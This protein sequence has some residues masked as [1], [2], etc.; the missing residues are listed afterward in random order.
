MN[1]VIMAGGTGG[2]VFPGLAVAEALRERDHKVWWLGAEGGMEE[3]LVQRAEIEMKSLPITGLRGKG[4]VRRLMMPWRMLR[5]TWQA[6]RFMRKHNIDVAISMGGYVAAP[7][8]LACRT[9]KT[10][11]VVHEQNSLFGMTNRYLSK[12][13]DLV[14][15][16]FDLQQQYASRWVG[17]PVR[18]SIEAKSY[19]Y[20]TERPTRVLILGGSLGAHALN[21]RLPDKLRSALEAGAI[22]IWHQCGKQHKAATEAAYAGKHQNVRI[23]EFIDDMAEAYAWA[24]C[25]ICR[26]GALTVAE[27]SVVGLPALLVPYPHAVDDHQRHNA[28]K[29]VE[30]KAAYMWLESDPEAQLEDY[31]TRLQ[32]S[33]T[34]SG[35]AMAMSSLGKAQV[36]EHIVDLCEELVS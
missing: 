27:I 2:H 30:A 15:T 9:L 31:I 26:A 7:G 21:T 18:A 12:W 16:G 10:R 14:L 1:C 23:H 5:S 24:D 22:E 34:R 8:G 36:A 17:N 19:Q 6:R 4:L 29:L 11:L 32:D 35:M 25:C 20:R 33:N 13:A 3:A 28:R